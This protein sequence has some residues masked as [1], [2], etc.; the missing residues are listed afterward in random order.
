LAT[1]TSVV[2]THFRDEPSSWRA[3]L[4]AIPFSARRLMKP[5]LLA[6]EEEFCSS[7]LT[8][9]TGWGRKVYQEL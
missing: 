9:C 6:E 7:S 1:L 5:S 2:E 3:R 8:F 4:E